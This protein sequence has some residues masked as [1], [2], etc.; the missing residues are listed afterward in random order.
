V[1]FMETKSI[2]EMQSWSFACFRM[3][4]APSPK[5]MHRL[6]QQFEH[7]GTVLEKNHR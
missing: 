7:D 3:Q 5:T 1:F 2:V 4:W 6:D